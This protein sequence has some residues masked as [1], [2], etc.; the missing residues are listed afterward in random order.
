MP[1]NGFIITVIELSGNWPR[2]GCEILA[3]FRRF[4]LLGA[5]MYTWLI[6][7]SHRPIFQ[8]LSTR[9]EG[10]TAQNNLWLTLCNM[11]DCVRILFFSKSPH[12]ATNN[13][14]FSWGLL[15]PLHLIT[16]TKQELNSPIWLYLARLK[17]NISVDPLL[18]KLLNSRRSAS[19]NG[20]SGVVIAPFFRSSK[21]NWKLECS[22]SLQNCL[23]FLQL[24][25]TRKSPSSI[26]SKWYTSNSAL[27]VGP[28]WLFKPFG[29]PQPLFDAGLDPR[30][31]EYGHVLYLK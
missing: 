11:R 30:V 20:V 10:T 6:S 9:R 27:K 15:V 26:S 16:L 19:S 12:A 31:L 7:R 8:S 3:F 18:S 2:N 1:Y 22:I 5:W 29:L 4:S 25:G 17:L 28:A 23:L 21:D 13:L 24:V 14:Y